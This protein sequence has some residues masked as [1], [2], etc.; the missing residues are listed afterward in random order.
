VYLIE[1]KTYVK[2][3]L[4][5]NWPKFQAILSGGSMELRGA[6]EMRNQ[7]EA[8]AAQY[9][10]ATM[11]PAETIV[12]EG[13]S[14]PCYVVHVTSD[15]R[16]KPIKDLH[17]DTTYWID[18]TALVFRKQ[19]EHDDNYLYVTST[20]HV[21]WHAD[22]TTIYPVADFNQQIAPETF[23]F[24]PPADAKE[25]ASLEPDLGVPTSNHP[26]A[27]I[28]GQMAPD[29]AFTR[30]DG[31]KIELSSYRG[32]PLLLDLWATWCA[33]CIESMPALN[34]ICNDVK[35]KSI[36]VVTVD[37]DATPE[38]ATNYLAR[39]NYG[40]TNY[41]DSGRAVEKALH[42]NGIP[43][44]VLI[45]AQGKIVY[46]DFGGDEAALRK[47]ITALGPQFT[48]VAPPGTEKP[49]ATPVVKTTPR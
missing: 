45:D 43:L 20:V 25:V 47:A 12:I 39:H 11:L 19:V 34:S 9:R 13:R 14:Y 3:P 46:Y 33:P 30:H 17:S 21:P 49:A 28:I 27:Q 2:R 35:D 10:H 5:T 16:S 18:K 37:Q 29:V 41:H 31:K 23:R 6:W 4:S 42:G 32:K 8:E 38:D 44:T 48:S 22:F 36:A 1:A 15:D 40:W 24:I 7:L 26:K